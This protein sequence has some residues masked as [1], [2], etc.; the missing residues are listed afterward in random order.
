MWVRAER[1]SSL[2]ASPVGR[3]DLEL[4]E[5]WGGSFRFLPVPPDPSL[6]NRPQGFSLLPSAH[7]GPTPPVVCRSGRTVGRA[8]HF[9]Q[10]R[11]VLT[12]GLEWGPRNA[13]WTIKIACG[14]PR[15]KDWVPEAAAAAV[16]HST[17]R[18]AEADGLAPWLAPRLGPVP[19]SILNLLAAMPCPSKHSTNKKGTSTTITMHGSRSS[20]RRPNSDFPHQDPSL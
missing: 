17:V 9:Y 18:P 2:Q 13:T 16:H 1:R 15:D 12:G 3:K 11:A 14:G 6:K 8:H 7:S 19:R 4:E 5:L 10:R 20:E